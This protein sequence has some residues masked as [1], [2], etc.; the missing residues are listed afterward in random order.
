MVINVL[1]TQPLE[2]C[3]GVILTKKNQFSSNVDI[4][5]C[6]SGPHRVVFSL[7]TLQH[8][9]LNSYFPQASLEAVSFIFLDHHILHLKLHVRALRCG[10][11][12]SSMSGSAPVFRCCLENVNIFFLLNFD[13]QEKHILT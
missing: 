12:P 13:L 10:G 5:S 8:T 1:C 4:L 6:I 9:F 2:K 7:F 11:L 3:T